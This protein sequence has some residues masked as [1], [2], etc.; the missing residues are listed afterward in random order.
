[1]PGEGLTHGPRAIKKH[2]EG[3]TGA[4]GSSGI[5]CAMALRL[6][7]RSPWGP[8]FLAPIARSVRHARELGLSVG[9]PGPRAFAVRGGS[10]RLTPCRVHRIPASRVVTM[11]IRPSPIEAGLREQIIHFCKSE[12]LYFSTGDWTAESPLNLL[13]N[14]DFSRTRFERLFTSA[15]TVRTRKARPT[16]KSVRPRRLRY[17]RG[18]RYRTVQNVALIPP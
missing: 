9:R 15:Q 2:G 7:A 18:A 3:T 11:R 17:E 8:G 5:P 13:A 10:V 12:A 1:M 4:A 14:F 16:G 6:M